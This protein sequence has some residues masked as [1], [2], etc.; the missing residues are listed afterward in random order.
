M[1]PT[2]ESRVAKALEEGPKGWLV[3]GG[4]TF[5]DQ[6]HTHKLHAENSL[7]SR[8]D[9]SE[10]LPLHSDHSALIRD[11]AAEVERLGKDAAELDRVVAALPGVCY[12]DPPDG[13]DVTVSEQVRRMAQD[14]ARYR[15]LR[16]STDPDLC[17]RGDESKS[18]GSFESYGPRDVISGLDLD[19]LV[20]A[21]RT[22]DSH[23]R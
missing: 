22:G 8:N 13:G 16:S 14:A 3:A 11:L 10:L 20:D 1:T 2:L 15:W 19:V 4:R 9:G 18:T 5:V 21:A 23:E 12:M 7:K 17:V 6:C